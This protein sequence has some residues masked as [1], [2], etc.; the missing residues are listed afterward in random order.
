MQRRDILTGL[1]AAIGSWTIG[2]DRSRGA[3]S[4]NS[5][6]SAP[7][8]KV[9]MSDGASIAL[10]KNGSGPSLLLVHGTSRT[11]QSWARVIPL[12]KTHYRT[13][14]MNRRGRVDRFDG[15]T[16]SVARE[17]KIS[18]ESSINYPPRFSRSAILMAR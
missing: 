14:A 18:R 12:L 11:R 7:L 17:A 9:P 3:D 1:V 10:E 13:F 2:T 4:S 8:L 16:F 15:S 6:P 5:L